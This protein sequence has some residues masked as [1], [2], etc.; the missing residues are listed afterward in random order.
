VDKVCYV[1]DYFSGNSILVVAENS[2]PFAIPCGYVGNRQP[3]QAL[4]V[5]ELHLPGPDRSLSIG[6]VQR[7]YT[8]DVNLDTDYLHENHDYTRC[9]TS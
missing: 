8:E 2:H 3:T 9:L 6:E 1:R 5:D 7:D 4:I